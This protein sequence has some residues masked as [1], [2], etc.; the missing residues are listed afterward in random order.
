MGSIAA[1]NA[2]MSTAQ[3]ATNGNL[4]SKAI[5]PEERQGKVE[6][7]N[8]HAARDTAND[9]HDQLTPPACDVDGREW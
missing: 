7:D 3:V 4:A 2:H 9:T 5:G 1:G 8:S 6:D